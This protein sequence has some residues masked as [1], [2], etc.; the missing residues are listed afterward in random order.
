MKSKP[1]VQDLIKKHGAETNPEDLTA[2]FKKICEPRVGDIVFYKN[3]EGAFQQVK[4]L[5]GQYLD[6]TYS[7]LSNFWTWEVIGETKQNQSYGNFFIE[8]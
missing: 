5:S 4:I 3:D 8:A 2:G 7:R 6:S 1:W